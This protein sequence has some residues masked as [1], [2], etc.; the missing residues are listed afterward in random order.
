MQERPYYPYEIFDNFIAVHDNFCSECNMS[1]LIGVKYQCTQC[2]DYNLCVFCEEKTTHEH[3]FIKMKKSGSQVPNLQETHEGVQKQIEQ[4]KLQEKYGKTI[5][6]RGREVKALIRQL[7]A[8]ALN[9]MNIK[10]EKP[11]RHENNQW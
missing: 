11:K 2:K 5:L 6:K 7:T 9:V 8:M 3:P 10:D 1:P 4:V